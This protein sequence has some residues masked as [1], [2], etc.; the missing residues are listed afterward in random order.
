MVC[1]EAMSCGLPV[2]GSNVGGIP[3]IVKDGYNGLLVE[4]GNIK[5]LEEGILTLCTKE[6]YRLELSHNAL[7]TAM[8]NT[9]EGQNEKFREAYMKYVYPKL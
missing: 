5:Q 3:E 6:E 7:K 9:Y 8:E 4:A 2:I 1:V